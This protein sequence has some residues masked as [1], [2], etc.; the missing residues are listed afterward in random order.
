M[1]TQ[2]VEGDVAKV[3]ATPVPAL[4][5]P[6]DLLAK[7]G[8]GKVTLSWDEPLSDGGSDIVRYE[9]RY[10][11][12]RSEVWMLWV[13]ETQETTTV[14]GLTNGRSYD[15]EVRAVNMQGEA[16]D[17]ATE[18]ATPVPRSRRRRTT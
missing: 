12:D 7:P 11:V 10:R 4:S 16:G 6:V 17:V 14:T 15:F 5:A 18:T 9:Y 2:N 3:T 1:D 13:W 8:D